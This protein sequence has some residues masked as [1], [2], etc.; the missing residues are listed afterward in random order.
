MVQV[1][2]LAEIKLH[3]D[4]GHVLLYRAKGDQRSSAMALFDLP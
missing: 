2:V 4:V 3:E 1:V